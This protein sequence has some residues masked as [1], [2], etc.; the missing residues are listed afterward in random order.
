M[1]TFKVTVDGQVYTVQVEEMKEAGNENTPTSKVAATAKNKSAESGPENVVSNKPATT[2]EKE[3]NTPEKPNGSGIKVNAP[4][5]GS[6]IEINV[7]T[8]D[9]VKEGDVLLVF[10]A[11]KME[12]ELTAP[13][14]GTVDKVL[15]KKSD[16]VNSGDT[17]VVLTP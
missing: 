14:A 6:I 9:T 2:A 13:Q 3:K 8:G 17:L 1:K 15:V 4:M 5:P 11:M 16:T 7:T 12:N 10:E